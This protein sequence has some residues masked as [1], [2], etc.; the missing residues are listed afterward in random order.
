MGFSFLPLHSC[1]LLAGLLG[2]I[3]LLLW[4]FFIIQQKGMLG[5]TFCIGQDGDLHILYSDS[6][7]LEIC[8]VWVLGLLDPKEWNQ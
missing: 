4:L 7:P 5:Y 2:T 8:C 6:G 3:I 1:G